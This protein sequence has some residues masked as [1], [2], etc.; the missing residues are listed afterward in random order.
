M[1]F[2]LCQL[3]KKDVAFVEEFI[4]NSETYKNKSLFCLVDEHNQIANRNQAIMLFSTELKGKTAWSAANLFF[5][6]YAFQ[7][8]RDLV[9][10]PDGYFIHK[11]KKVYISP[12]INT[13]SVASIQDGYGE[14]YNVLLKKMGNK[15][16][17]EEFLRNTKRLS[18]KIAYQLSDYFSS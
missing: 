6:H 1:K 13:I 16:I 7:T 11:T 4:Q 15:H 9:T 18:K 14:E 10:N 2:K 5:Y 3:S 17:D 8:S 12:F